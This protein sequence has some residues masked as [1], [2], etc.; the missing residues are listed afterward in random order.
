LPAK[1]KK[2]SNNVLDATGS[3]VLRGR[4]GYRSYISDAMGGGESDAVVLSEPG[5]VENSQVK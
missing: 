2:G 5:N 3:V 4:P 1:G